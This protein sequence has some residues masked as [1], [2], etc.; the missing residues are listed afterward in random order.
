MTTDIFTS[1][2]FELYDIPVA[3]EVDL[4]KVQQRHRDL[5]K[6]VHPD[7]FVNASDLEK[8][9]SMQQTSLINEAFNTLRQPVA[10]A[11]YLLKLKGIDLNLE[12]ET[13]MDVD[14][15]MEQ[16]EMREALSSVSSRDDP[17]TELD[18]FSGQIKDKMKNMMESFSDSYENEKLDDAREWIRKMQFMQKAKKE[19][20]ELSAKIEDELF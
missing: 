3:Y 4:E 2:F 20:D 8:R 12:N 19:V 11:I 16:I 5:Q 14:F 7:K 13:T 1:N 15:L 9:I 10:R 17:L 6:A 18:H